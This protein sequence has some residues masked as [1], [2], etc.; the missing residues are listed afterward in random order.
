M[1]KRS[2]GALNGKTRKL[3]GKSKVSVASYMKLFTVGQ[4]VVITPKAKWI[5]MPHLRYSNKHGTVV[6]K[7]GTSYVVEVDDYKMKKK[8]IVA[9]IHMTAA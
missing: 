7:R 1:V 4:H 6:E 5:G 2:K 9:P 8:I 3:K